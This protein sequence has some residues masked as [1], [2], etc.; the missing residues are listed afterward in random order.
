[1]VE[2]ITIPEFEIVS[3]PKISL[4]DLKNYKYKPLYKGKMPT[5]EELEET[6]IASKNW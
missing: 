5:E 6:R 4:K 1:M 3:S 2:R